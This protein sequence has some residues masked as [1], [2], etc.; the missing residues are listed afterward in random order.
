MTDDVGFGWIGYLG[1][2]SGLVALVV[3]VSRG[4]MFDVWVL[5]CLSTRTYL[6]LD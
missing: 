1:N 4:G 6:L 2:V 5:D 3:V